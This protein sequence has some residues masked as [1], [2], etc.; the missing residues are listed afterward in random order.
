[1]RHQWVIK[2]PPLWHLKRIRKL[3]FDWRKWW[4]IV[5]DSAFTP[6]ISQL[7]SRLFLNN[8]D[9]SMRRWNIEISTVIL[10]WVIHVDVAIFPLK[11]DSLLFTSTIYYSS[12]HAIVGS[13]FC[14]H[15]SLMPRR[16]LEDRA[17]DLAG[18]SAGLGAGG[19]AAYNPCSLMQ[20]KLLCSSRIHGDLRGMPCRTS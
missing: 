6:I 11:K 18:R 10:H 16:T 20:L 19:S 3:Q 4:V 1:M 17:K 14:T 5:D 15:Y 8:I 9:I 12:E 13:S 2:R 7:S